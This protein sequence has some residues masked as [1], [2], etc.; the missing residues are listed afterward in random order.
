MSIHRFKLATALFTTLCATSSFAT[1]VSTPNQQGLWLQKQPGFFRFSFDNVSMPNDGPDMGFMGLNYF[2]DIT[3][4]LYGGIGAYGA[5]SGNQGGFF[6]LGAEAGVHREFFEN[7]WGDAGMFIGGGGGRSSLVG[8]GLMLRPHVGIAYDF[9]WVRLG[10]HYSYIHFPSG[11]IHS[12]Q[13]GLDLDIPFDFYYV[14]IQDVSNNLINVANIHLLNGKFLD[15]QRN[16]FSIILQAYKQKPGT[17]N[18]NDQVQDGTMG[19]I[20][21]EL[22]HY[23][24]DNTFWW[25][26]AGGAFHG[27]PNGYMDVIG[28]FGYHWA[29]MRNGIALVPQLGVGAG[30]GGNV[31]TGGGVLI[32]PQLGL[33]VP[34]T[35][36]FAARL[37]GGYLWA[38]TGELSA[39]TVTGAI[40]YHLN[41]ATAS[42][43]PVIKLA[44]CY[45]TQAWR[46]QLFNQTYISPQHAFSPRDTSINLIGVQIDQLFTPIFFFSYQ[47]ASAYSGW[48]A[49]G[50]ASGM[51]GPGIQ[52]PPFL[53]QRLQ[54]FGE[55]LVGAAG[56]GGLSLGGGAIVE[57]VVGLH[58][59]LSPAIGLQA[60]FSQIKA[61]NNDLNTPVVNA[62]L[63][64]KFGTLD[65]G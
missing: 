48:H 59:A 28:G 45:S 13:V 25:V 12:S 36:N 62:G 52:T 32:Q 47:A 31:D 3:P 2:A 1:E 61:V 35:S 44:D 38:P 42:D 9:R 5:V 51:I 17:L 58:Y 34:L 41:V 22:D 24:T 54:L 30:G 49:G 18:V 10:L 63:T 60:S 21:A 65:R 27:V 15:F 56:G 20:G 4:N 8:G 40:I 37:S 23:F 50:L 39:Y 46:I 11:E 53:N 57:P 33:E 29:L 26:K 16:D 55:F 43:K 7:W 14:R 6:T 19:V 64:I